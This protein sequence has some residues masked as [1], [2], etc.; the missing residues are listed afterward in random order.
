M[1]SFNESANSESSQIE[2]ENDNNNQEEVSDDFI[3]EEQISHELGNG[4]TSRSSDK[5]RQSYNITDDSKIKAPLVNRKSVVPRVS[6]LHPVNI[7]RLLGQHEPLQP[8]KNS[9]NKTNEVS[10]IFQRIRDMET[11]NL[12][13]VKS[14]LKDNV[15][16]ST[17]FNRLSNLKKIQIEKDKASSF[18]VSRSRSFK[19]EEENSVFLNEKKKEEEPSPNRNSNHFMDYA[20]MAVLMKNGATQDHLKEL[21]P[22]INFTKEKVGIRRN[23][24]YNFLLSKGGE[25]KLQEPGSSGIKSKHRESNSSFD[26]SKFHSALLSPKKLKKNNLKGFLRRRGLL[27][28]NSET[29]FTPL[30]N[31]QSATKLNASTFKK[32][33]DRSKLNTSNFSKTSQR[34]TSMENTNSQVD[35]GQLGKAYNK[36]MNYL[37]LGILEGENR[38][39]SRPS[40]EDL[41]IGKKDGSPFG[42]KI[43]ASLAESEKSS[44]RDKRFEVVKEVNENDSL[45]ATKGSPASRKFRRFLQKSNFKFSKNLKSKNTIEDTM[46]N[47][48]DL[49]HLSPTSEMQSNIFGKKLN[50]ERN[51]SQDSL[52]NSL[53]Y[54]SSA[55]KKSHQKGSKGNSVESLLKSKVIFSIKPKQKLESPIR[56]L[57]FP[58]MVD[59]LPRNVCLGPQGTKNSSSGHVE[60]TANSLVNGLQDD[61]SQYGPKLKESSITKVIFSRF[62]PAIQAGHHKPME[63]SGNLKLKQSESIRKFAKKALMRVTKK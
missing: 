21:F 36:V 27:M 33:H 39:E 14:E 18:V 44:H 62:R 59:N 35:L 29:G 38:T 49:A 55:E 16:K 63:E 30:R 24:R 46:M 53:N 22:N 60:M 7:H 8:T 61:L 1:E 19:K 12:A 5:E 51:L 57:K 45:L 37:N 42:W 43:L 58:S 56:Q 9:L 6:V 52:E 11:V 50:I 40:K 2:S 13:S 32:E 10:S 34:Q 17:S 25:T 3:D 54:T 20:R 28:K 47:Q 15:L 31:Q 23:N 26:S 48:P 4:N 41:D